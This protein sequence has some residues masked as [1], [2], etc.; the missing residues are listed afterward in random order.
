MKNTLY[1]MEQG[2]IRAAEDNLQKLIDSKK[3]ID[4][5][6]IKN[7]RFITLKPRTFTCNK[8]KCSYIWHIIL[9]W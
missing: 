6:V 8:D 1:Q 3:I 9:F 7:F 2:R 5:E 4:H